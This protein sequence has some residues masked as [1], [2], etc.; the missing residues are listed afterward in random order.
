M[1]KT[2]IL[3]IIDTWWEHFL[4][5]YN[6]RHGPFMKYSDNPTE[7]RADLRNRLVFGS[8]SN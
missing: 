5:V 6:A 8:D 7:Q 2:F 1:F 3:D 4:F